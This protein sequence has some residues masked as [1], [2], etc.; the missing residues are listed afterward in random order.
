MGC[1]IEYVDDEHGVDIKLNRE[2]A[3]FDNDI[4]SD[5]LEL[6]IKWFLLM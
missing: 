1:D 4:D 6:P 2:R 5:D 3:Y